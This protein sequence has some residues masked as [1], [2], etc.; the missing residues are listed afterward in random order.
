MATSRSR[1]ART[2]RRSFTKS[3]SRPSAS[4][5]DGPTP[6]PSRVST[7][8]R[9]RRR[10]PKLL[11]LVPV[12]L[13]VLVLATLV[14][15]KATG[16][17]MATPTASKV[18]TGKRGSVASISGTTALPA[19]VLSDAAS[20]SPATLAAIGR[21][22]ASV[23]PAPT[24]VK[25][26]LIA[27]DGKPEILFVSAEY[28]PFCAA[29]R[30][31]LVV[32]LSR[33]GSFSRLSA[34]HSSTT[35]VFPNTKSFSF[36]GATYSS[37]TLNFTSVELQ[38]NYVS[39]NAYATLQTPTTAEDDILSKYDAAPYTSQPGSIPFLDIANKYVSVGSGYSPQL[40]QGLSLQQIAAQLNNKDSPVATAIDGEANRITAAI[41]AATGVE[42]DQGAAGVSPASNS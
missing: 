13:V 31:P 9:F 2:S 10:H 11:A 37:S 33:F 21:S 15:I 22:S 27:S 42:P 25:K 14:I 5:D 16:S 6:R 12:A 35:D 19:G 24:E 20:V 4:R 40:L 39:G 26:T 34:T 38:T 18:V 17:S 28:C 23:A 3:R 7:G 8:A 41:T 32:A 29:Q 36:Y 1:P 30:W